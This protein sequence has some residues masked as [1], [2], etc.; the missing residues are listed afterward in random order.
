MRFPARTRLKKS[1]EFE[2]VRHAGRKVEYGPFAMQIASDAVPA[3]QKPV[4]R[5]GVVA[6]KRV[7]G[8][9]QRNRAKR[10]LRAVFR[11]NQDMLPAHCDVVLLAR[12]SLPTLTIREVEPVYQ[13]ALA[14]FAKYRATQ[15]SREAAPVVV[16]TVSN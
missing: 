7:G 2:R 10:L 16:T 14:K 11:S 13:Q 9:V 8:A 12:P 3:Q 5:L 6:S 15:A 4:R 1:A